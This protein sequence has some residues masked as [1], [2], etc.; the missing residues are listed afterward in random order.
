MNPKKKIID[1]FLNDPNCNN[2]HPSFGTLSNLESTPDSSLSRTAPASDLL[3]LHTPNL[4]Y[5]S[6]SNSPSSSVFNRPNISTSLH[7][8]SSASSSSSTLLDDAFPFNI[9]MNEDK[10]K[11]NSFL[12]Y[13]FDH[14]NTILLNGI[15]LFVDK[16]LETKFPRFITPNQ[17]NERE[18]EWN[19]PYGDK[20]ADTLGNSTLRKI[21]NVKNL[22]SELTRKFHTRESVVLFRNH[23]LRN[24]VL[25][26]SGFLGHPFFFSIFNNE[27]SSLNKALSA[28]YL[29]RLFLLR[30]KQCILMNISVLN[31]LYPLT[32]WNLNVLKF[33]LACLYDEYLH[34]GIH[35]VLHTRTTLPNHFWEPCNL[36]SNWLRSFSVTDFLAEWKILA[37]ENKKN[38][39]K[40][41]R[42]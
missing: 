18:M 24:L 7:L 5:S 6:Q 13:S 9:L 2:D 27:S 10:E 14:A 28:L 16:E 42:T 31:F 8:P 17:D 21:N 35:H 36:F 22:F 4:G 29:G 39:K 20:H 41:K 1:K 26:S 38:M 12:R 30:Y 32:G 19:D 11:F 37:K 40:R 33:S 34:V 15:E 25:F 3:A 23:H